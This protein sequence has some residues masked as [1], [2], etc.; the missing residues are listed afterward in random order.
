MFC[1]K[2]FLYFLCVPL[3]IDEHRNTNRNWHSI[4]DSIRFHDRVAK[5][6]NCEVSVTVSRH[7]YLAVTPKLHVACAFQPTPLR[8]FLPQAL[9]FFAN[10]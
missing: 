6:R 3:G 1:E 5:S 4:H 9:N 10:K 7:T 8:Y 2:L